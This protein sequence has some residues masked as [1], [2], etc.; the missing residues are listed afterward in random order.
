MVAGIVAA[1][2]NALVLLT[3]ARSWQRHS[4][5]ESSPGPH[6][7]ELNVV[8]GLANEVRLTHQG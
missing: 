6:L 8:Q 7:P 4:R 5:Q 1:H 2:L 3:S